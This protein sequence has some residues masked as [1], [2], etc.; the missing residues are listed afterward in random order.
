MSNNEPSIEI[1]LTL[2][3]QQDLRKLAKRYRSIRQDLTPLI[4]QLQQGETPG[5]LISGNK[6]QVI[7]VR[8]KNSDIQKGK[9]AGYRV[10][11]YLKT[12]TAIILV[13]IYSKSDLTDIPNK[14][15]QE[16]IQKFESGN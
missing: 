9:S 11:Y 5:D 16:I 12:P 1:L 6:Y 3:F 15:I 8:L 2:R 7:K 14:V 4:Q 13:T 10:I